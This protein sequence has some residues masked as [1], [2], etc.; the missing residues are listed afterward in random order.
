MADVETGAPP[1]PEDVTAG[2]EGEEEPEIKSEVSL[3]SKAVRVVALAS[4]VCQI[5]SIALAYSSKIVLAAGLIGAFIAPIVLVRQKQLDMVGSM[6]T[7][8][9]QL[10]QDV[11]DMKTE[12]AKLSSSVDML[13]GEVGR[14][15]TVENSL[16]EITNDVEMNVDELVELCGENEMI[17]EKMI[18]SSLLFLL[19]N[20]ICTIFC[21]FLIGQPL[22]NYHLLKSA[23]FGLKS[24]SKYDSACIDV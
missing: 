1:E 12:N 9:N 21:I 11:N 2:G 5:A 8:T 13:E 16:Q 20:K 24:K 10:R 23:N 17:Q 14:L 22:L 18:V 6:R 7:V 15:K 4:L 3:V 19:C